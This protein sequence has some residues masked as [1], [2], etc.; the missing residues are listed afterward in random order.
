MTS[1]ERAEKIVTDM[2]CDSC[3]HTL[4]MRK[5]MTTL[6]A[7]QI[8]EAIL[9]ASQKAHSISDAPCSECFQK[10]W[11]AAREKAKGIAE[12]QS[13]VLVGRFI[14]DRIGKMEP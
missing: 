7:A 5:Q 14:A 9:E 11:N 2:D 4:E 1:L 3:Q 6:I 10:G 12:E 8:E 13:A